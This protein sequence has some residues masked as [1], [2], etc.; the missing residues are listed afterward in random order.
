MLNK[1]LVCE[2]EKNFSANVARHVP[3]GAATRGLRPGRGWC[4]RGGSGG[5]QQKKSKGMM[6][7]VRAARH[8]LLCNGVTSVK[9]SRP[10]ALRVVYGPVVVWVYR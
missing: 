1:I 6:G 8:G 2:V 9:N 4:C 5:P 10:R 3:W 7:R